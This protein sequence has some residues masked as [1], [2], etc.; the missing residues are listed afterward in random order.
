MGSLKQEFWWN[1]MVDDISKV[2]RECDCC[3]KARA[4]FSAHKTLKPIFKGLQPFQIWSIDSIPNLA[5]NRGLVIVA[6]DCFSK[7]VEIGLVKSHAAIDVWHWF[8]INVI[9][10]YG[11]PFV[12][13]SDQGTEYKGDFSSNCRNWGIQIR[14]ASTRYPQANGQAER[15]VGLIKAALIKFCAALESTTDWQ[16]YLGEVLMGLRYC[17][18]RS[19]GITPYRV[20]FGKEPSLP[21]SVK[22]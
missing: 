12:V 18:T 5:G 19:H 13:R 7:C 22:V 16:Q 14:R 15:F 20:I 17:V 4:K 3:Q 21:S 9:C 6:V 1:G 11:V 10:R 8:Y 2:V